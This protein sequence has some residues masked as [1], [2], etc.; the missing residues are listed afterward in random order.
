MKSYR[1]FSRISLLSKKEI[2]PLPNNFLMTSL[3]KTYFI[4]SVIYCDFKKIVQR[5]FKELH[6]I[7]VSAQLA[8]ILRSR[9][10]NKIRAKR[11]FA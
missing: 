11:F 2:L 4:V 7:F 10:L 5:E 8:H 3:L 6:E 1:V 9:I